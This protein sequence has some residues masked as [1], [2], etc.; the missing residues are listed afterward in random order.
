M[1]HRGG[2]FT[3]D[4]LD[5]F[6]NDAF[7]NFLCHVGI[8][9]IRFCVEEARENTGR[10]FIARSGDAFSPLDNAAKAKMPFLS[11][12]IFANT[13]HRPV[14]ILG[15][16]LSAWKPLEPDT[17]TAT[18]IESHLIEIIRKRIQLTSFPIRT[19]LFL[20][21]LI[22][23]DGS[24]DESG[25]IITRR[26]DFLLLK[27]RCLYD[28]ITHLQQNFL[29]AIL[30]P[31]EEGEVFV[32]YSQT[33]IAPEPVQHIEEPT[34]SPQK[35]KRKHVKKRIVQESPK[36]VVMARKSP[37]KRKNV[38][39]E[40]QLPSTVNAKSLSTEAVETPAVEEYDLFPDVDETTLC[41]EYRVILAWYRAKHAKKS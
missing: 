21:A 7:R 31:V 2:P 25:E 9:L 41:F 28:E 37:S 14:Y 3:I 4:G 18:T 24:T 27:L 15:L 26:R 5:H 22:F 34:E 38:L 17:V 40:S 23:P 6:S 35:E 20:Y 39:T 36:R 29:R 8:K 12:S 10:T 11:E 30:T 16:W 13:M 1:A 32:Y 33:Q 19:M